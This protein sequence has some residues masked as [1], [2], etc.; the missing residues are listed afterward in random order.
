[1]KTRFHALPYYHQQQQQQTDDDNVDGWV[2]GGKTLWWR[3]KIR[4]RF[5]SKSKQDFKRTTF[6]R[7]HE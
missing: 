3:G 1:M 5:E 4:A 2:V 6:L 7:P